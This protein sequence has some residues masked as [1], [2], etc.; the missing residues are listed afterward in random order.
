MDQL[1]EII[2]SLD[3]S[4]V[5]QYK[6]Y[7]SRVTT[8]PER[9]DLMLFDLIR[10]KGLEYDDEKIYKRLYGDGDKN[11][12][13]RLRNRLAEEIGKSIFLMQQDEDEE[14]QCYYQLSL[15]NYFFRKGNYKLSFSYYT[16]VEKKAAALENFSLL[17]TV[18]S[19]LITL[20]KKLLTIDPEDY[21]QKR[22]EN[23][24][25]LRKISE[26]ED[27]LE[28]VEYRI[29][30]SQNYGSNVQLQEML[31]HTVN[32]FAGDEEFKSSARLQLALH[33]VV[34]Q[35]L[36]QQKNYPALEEYLGKALDELEQKG[37]FTRKTHFQKLQMLTWLANAA[38]KNRHFQQSLACA[39]KLRAAME[40][41]DRLYYDRF[42]FFY[43]NALVINFSEI[44]LGKAIELLEE[45]SSQ[46]KMENQA[47]Y[48]LFIYL[49]L[50]LFY[51]EK[52]N[53]KAAMRNLQKLYKHK[54]YE[55]TDAGMK[56]RVNTGE[57]M[58]RYDLKEQEV[59]AYR[60]RQ[61]M[62][63]FEA[64]IA[65]EEYHEEAEFLSVYNNLLQKGRQT[66][67]MESAKKFVENF[68]QA[69]SRKEDSFFKYDDWLKEKLNLNG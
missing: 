46:K 58:L 12:Y 15:A 1:G 66:D 23:R 63:D 67:V 51:F 42:E 14:T 39:E 59:A 8:I 53:Y 13:Y 25:K 16:R 57:L 32:E 33:Q 56:L 54:G 47:Y 28:V 21:I 36:L 55:N 22:K 65:K 48:G 18:Y 19:K 24:E 7:A 26:L 69:G 9:K 2:A 20:S 6:I 11:A 61:I 35:T 3:R 49:N 34:A 17:E 41:F 27:V 40:E 30:K 62:K 5:K 60:L 29:K 52:R 43:Y 68:G 45:L 37:L 31:D 10:Q 64:L 4:E 50:T 38:F 44:N